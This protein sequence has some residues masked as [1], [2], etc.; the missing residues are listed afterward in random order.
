MDVY[1]PV[2]ALLLLNNAIVLLTVLFHLP[3]SSNHQFLPPFSSFSLSRIVSYNVYR[4]SSQF[5]NNCQGKVINI[6]YE[7]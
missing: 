1:F 5:Y 4:A 3:I 2:S 6:L 7:H